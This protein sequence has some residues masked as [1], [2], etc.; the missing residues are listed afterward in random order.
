MT[1][2]SKSSDFSFLCPQNIRITKCIR[3]CGSRI[4]F[5]EVAI[6]LMSFSIK[7]LRIHRKLNTPWQWTYNS[8][9]NYCMAYTKH[10]IDQSLYDN[11]LIFLLLV[12]NLRNRKATRITICNSLR[13]WRNFTTSAPVANVLWCGS[14]AFCPLFP[15]Q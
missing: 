7:T 14:S 3:M 6:D 12:T 4:I 8:D 1:L 11:N 5:R 9:R 2:K 10:N 15:N 13:R